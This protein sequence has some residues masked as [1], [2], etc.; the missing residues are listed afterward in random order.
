MPNRREQSYQSRPVSPRKSDLHSS[1]KIIVVA[2]EKRRERER[3]KFCLIALFE[4]G[5]NRKGDKEREGE[6]KRR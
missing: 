4:I 1:I 5:G 3:E 2:T 6:G